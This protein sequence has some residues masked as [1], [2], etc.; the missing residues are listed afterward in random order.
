MII[1]QMFGALVGFIALVQVVVWFAFGRVGSMVKLR[2]GWLC[3]VVGGRGQG[4]N[5]FCSRLIH[6][7]L[8][9]GIPVYATFEIDHPLAFKVRTWR[10]VLLAPRGS[11][12]LIDEGSGWCG[13]RAGATLR[14]LAM[15]V[16]SRIRHLFLEVWIIAQHENQI[17]G[18]VRD[19]INEIIECKE[20]VKGRHRATSWAPHEFRKKAANKLWSWHYTVKGS[21]TW[22]YDTHDLEPPERS[23]SLKHDDDYDVIDEC[24][25]ILRARRADELAAASQV[26]SWLALAEPASV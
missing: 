16:I 10:D 4:K 24:I 3:L 9:A 6:A 2:P 15:F 8:E 14:P 17:A 26:D 25:E 7:R 22:L 20:L 18:G 19:Q 21:P 1:W 12:V 23:R 13:A 11:M 5:L